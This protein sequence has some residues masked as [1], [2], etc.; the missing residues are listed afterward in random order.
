MCV[1]FYTKLI[2][3]QFYKKKIVYGRTNA[4]GDHLNRPSNFT[5]GCLQKNLTPGGSA[6]HQHLAVALC[7]KVVAEVEKAKRCVHG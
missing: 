5:R 2:K 1:G 7:Q 4:H 6:V 3:T